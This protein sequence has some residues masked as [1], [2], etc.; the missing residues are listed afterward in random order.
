MTTPN[1]NPRDHYIALAVRLEQLAFTLQT[2]HRDPA[3]SIDCLE[4]AQFVRDHLGDSGAADQ[5]SQ[6]SETL[7]EFFERRIRELSDDD[8]KPR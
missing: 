2:V 5:R 7:F 8:K 4:A 1:D 6:H 3:A